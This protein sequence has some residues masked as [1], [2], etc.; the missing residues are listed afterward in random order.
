MSTIPGYTTFSNS[1]TSS[2]RTRYT[3]T[4][5]WTSSGG[6]PSVGSDISNGGPITER[7]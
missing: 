5:R 3:S 7:T 2:Y 1:P 6:T 4:T